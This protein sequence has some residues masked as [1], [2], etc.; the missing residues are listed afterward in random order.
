[1]E[2]KK[3]L[4]SKEIFWFDRNTSKN[5]YSS[6]AIFLNRIW[7]LREKIRKSKAKFNIINVFKNNFKIFKSLM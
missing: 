1:M 5:D 3:M 7:I 2:N 4:L 6:M